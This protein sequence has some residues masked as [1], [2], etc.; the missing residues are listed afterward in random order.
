MEEKTLVAN[1]N[2]HHFSTIRSLIESYSNFFSSPVY[3][4]I[5]LKSYLTIISVGGS[6]TEC[7]YISDDKT[8]THI[9][10]MKLKSVF[11]RVWI[12]NAGLDGHSTFGHII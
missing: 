8:W 4:Y 1:S 12:N 11:T 3:L 9:L 10:G 7:F 6:T 2:D 5:I